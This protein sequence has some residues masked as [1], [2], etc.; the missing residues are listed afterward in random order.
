VLSGSE[1]CVHGFD[2][3]EVGGGYRE[4]LHA[5]G[6]E[7]LHAGGPVTVVALPEFSCAGLVEIAHHGQLAPVVIGIRE[8]MVLAPDTEADD[9]DAD[10]PVHRISL[11]RR[12]LP[13]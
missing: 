8:G 7:F 6:S 11:P 5:A 13:D 1:E 2:V 9:S 4:N 3:R 12:A 10:F